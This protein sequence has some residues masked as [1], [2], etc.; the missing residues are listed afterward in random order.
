MFLKKVLLF[1][2]LVSILG[3]PT[4]SAI[5]VSSKLGFLGGLQDEFDLDF[6]QMTLGDGPL[7]GISRVITTVIHF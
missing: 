3:V 2:Y 5:T 6:W 7:P 1:S 4:D